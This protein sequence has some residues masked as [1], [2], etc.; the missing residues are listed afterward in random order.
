MLHRLASGLPRSAF[1]GFRLP[2]EVIV[3]S[4]R[5]L[6]YGL[7]YRDVE[8]QLAEHGIE[9]DRVPVYR[10]VQRFT[11]LL[12]LELSVVVGTSGLRR[13]NRRSMEQ[14]LDRRDDGVTGLRDCSSSPHHCPTATHADI[15]NK[16]VYLRARS[17][18]AV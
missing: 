4:V 1:V 10:W 7:S 9:A 14:K 16:I 2:A 5:Y 13:W 17:S 3:V 12:A 18:T 15:V 8:E 6:R 11:P